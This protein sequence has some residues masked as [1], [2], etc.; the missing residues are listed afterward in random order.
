MEKAVNRKKSEISNL[1]AKYEELVNIHND[2]VSEKWVL[3]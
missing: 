1:V 3:F 2:K